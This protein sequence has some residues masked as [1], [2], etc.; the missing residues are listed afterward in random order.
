MWK[1]AVVAFFTKL[2]QILSGGNEG[3]HGKVVRTAALRAEISVWDLPNI[4]QEW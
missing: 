4:K 3:N 1:T 2:F